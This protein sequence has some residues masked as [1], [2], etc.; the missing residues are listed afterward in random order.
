MNLAETL[1]LIEALKLAGVTKYKSFEHDIVFNEGASTVKIQG[2]SLQPSDSPVVENK[3]A[4]EQIKDLTSTLRM[5]PEEL[6]NKIFPD[7]AL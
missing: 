5:S 6:A 7:G 4:T 1:A 2:E 3:E